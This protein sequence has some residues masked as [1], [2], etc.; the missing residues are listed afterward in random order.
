VWCGVG[1]EW[2][3]GRI[4]RKRENRKRELTNFEESKNRKE[5]KRKR[6]SGLA[7]SSHLSFTSYVCTARHSMCK[8]DSFT[9]GGRTCSQRVGRHPRM[10][11]VRRDR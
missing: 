10:D 7:L 1:C 9:R 5:Q 3:T 11:A 6:E 2:L 4:Q 8:A